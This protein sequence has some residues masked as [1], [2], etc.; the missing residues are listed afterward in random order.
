MADILQALD[1]RDFAALAFLDLSAAF[2]TVDHVT[3]LRRIELS[4]GIRGMALSWL[5]S[6]LSDRTQF[7]RSGSTSPRPAVL[8][9]GVP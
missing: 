6:Y 8:R 3:L 4:Y 7:V 2:D 9:Y 5:R 1:R